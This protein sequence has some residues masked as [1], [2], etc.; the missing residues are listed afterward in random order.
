MIAIAF[1][2]VAA[3]VVIARIRLLLITAMVT[4]GNSKFLRVSRR[5]AAYESLPSIMPIRPSVLRTV[6]RDP[7]NSV[8]PCLM[9]VMAANYHAV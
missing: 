1:V 2:N 3:A 8:L 5:L 6:Q 7:C 9:M 4:F